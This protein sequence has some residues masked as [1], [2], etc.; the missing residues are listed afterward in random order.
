MPFAA[1][2]GQTIHYQDSAPE[3]GDDTPLIILS[4]GF[5]MD[6]EMWAHQ[7]GPLSAAGWR[8]VAH[9]ERGWGQ[10]IH[11]G[12]FD[13]WDLA[14]DVLGLMDHLGI[15]HAVLGGM[16]QGGFLSLRAALTAP[17]RV[18]ALVRVDSEAGIYTD[19]EAA[20]FQALF[21]AAMAMGMVGDMGDALQM[22]LFGADFADVRYWRGK[23]ASRPLVQWLDAKECLF[24]R[25]DITDR[26]GEITCPAITFHGDADMGIPIDD[27]RALADGLGGPSEFVVVPGAGHSANLEKPDLVNPPLLAFLAGLD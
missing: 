16:S 3:A 21:E 24:G 14:S 15:D 5:A 4:H 10:T 1:V 8:V 20:G 25:D 27:G 2:N 18:R 12:P 26:L 17:Q 6:H 13:Y 9:D 7:V 11:D 23:W 22:F 19:E